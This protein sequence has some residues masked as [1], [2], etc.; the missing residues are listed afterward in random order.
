MLRAEEPEAGDAAMGHWTSLD[1][2]TGRIAAWR[3]DP[4]VAPRGSLVVVQEIFGVNP[5]IRSVVDRFAAHGFTA[6][7]PALFDHLE[8]RV[9]LDYDAPGVA[10]GRDLVARLGFDR[11]VDDVR[12]AAES[13]DAPRRAGVVGF[14]WGGTVAFLA[15]ARLGMPAV[16]YYGGRT[17]PFLGEKPTAPLLLHFGEDDPIIPAEDRRKHRDALPGVEMHTWPAGHGFNCDQRADFN[18]QVAAQALERTLA[19]LGANL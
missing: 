8:P 17:V 10:R 14:C 12:V 13:L 4:A 19:F 2:P 6:I 9:E 3:A 5:H 7:A 18:P 1:T 11:A 15:C 16:S